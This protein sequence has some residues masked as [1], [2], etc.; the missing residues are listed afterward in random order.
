MNPQPAPVRLIAFYLPQ[1]HPIPEND[2]WWGKGFTEWTNVTKAKPLFKGHYQPHLPGELGFYD[3]RV[4][5][6]REHQAALARSYGISGFCYWHYWFSGK[7]L[8]ERPFAEVLQSGRPD[9]PFCLGWANESW[10]RRWH[11]GENA[12]EIFLEQRHSVADD[13]AHTQWLATAFADR[14]YIQ[15]DGRPMLL[16]WRPKQLPEPRRTTDTIRTECTRLGLPEP[17]LVGVDGSVS[18]FDMRQIGFDIL[19]HHS[20]RFDALPDCLTEGWTMS[21]FRRNLSQGAISRWKKIYRYDYALEQMDRLPPQ[22][23]HFPC[24]LVGWDN[25]PRRAEQSIILTETTPARF[26]AELEAL[27]RSVA[28]KPVEHRIVFINA[29]NEWAEGMHLEP[30]QR[31]GHA[32]LQAVANAIQS[33]QSPASGHC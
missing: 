26:Q 14:R 31:H 21:R 28:H 22:F 23:P 17:F 10:S 32:F 29:W 9:F 30:D 1:F 2:A 3:L 5:E 20:P 25:T 12:R 8:L 33:T 27:I 6:V 13:V 19:E 4:P 7:R 11:G 16:I 24:A 15:V 18:G